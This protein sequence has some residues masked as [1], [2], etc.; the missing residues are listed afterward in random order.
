MSESSIQF[1]TYLSGLITCIKSDHYNS[2]VAVSNSEGKIS[3]INLN[4]KDQQ[5]NITT[6][7][8]HNQSIWGLS[9]S[10]PKFGNFLASCSSDKTVKIWKENKLLS[11]ECIYIFKGHS[12]I[13]TNCEF[14]P[15]EYGFE[16]FCSS[17][18]GR[19]SIHY[20]N[21]GNIE[22]TGNLLNQIHSNGIISFSFGP[23]L[24]PINFEKD[25][26]NIYPKDNSQINSLLP[27]KIMSCGGDGH[28]KVVVYDGK[29]VSIETDIDS[30][31]QNT[32]IDVAW[33]SYVGYTED[34][35]AI[36]CSDKTV[37]IIKKE[38]I[39]SNWTT[40]Y[41]ITLNEECSKVSWSCCGSYLGVSMK[42]NKIR[43][44][45]EN[46]DGN[47]EEVEN[48]SNIDNKMF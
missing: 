16:L 8:A 2:K 30:F 3:I 44:F 38:D 29:E 17:L 45:Q 34:T 14:A 13:V 26:E 33:L 41:T 31:I 15:S 5:K 4:N 22:W 23:I 25:F 12:D 28:I 40:S 35:A 7:Q 18:D 9:W 48:M 39:N 42:N 6:F 46:L 20:R 43:I 10:D 21:P 24:P 37:K 27:L 47:W 32:P 11:Y 1:S 36:C 19:L